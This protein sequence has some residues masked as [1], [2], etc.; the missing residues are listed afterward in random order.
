MNERIELVSDREVCVRRYAQSTVGTDLTIRKVSDGRWSFAN[1]CFDREGL[2]GVLDA[3]HCAL[4]T[5]DFAALAD[6]SA[7]GF[8]GKKMRA[9]LAA[10]CILEG[11][12]VA[13]VGKSWHVQLTPGRFITTSIVLPLAPATPKV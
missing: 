13:S 12:L 8:V 5:P 11:A 1:A 10:D 4:D 3:V 2:Q 9:Q 7:V 6:T